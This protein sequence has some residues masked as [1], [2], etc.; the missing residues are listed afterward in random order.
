[1]GYIPELIDHVLKKGM[2]GIS[3]REGG[4]FLVDRDKQELNL[5]LVF[6]KRDEK[7]ARGYRL[8]L[9]EGIAGR[10]VSEDRHIVLHEVQEKSFFNYAAGTGEER[11]ILCVPLKLSAKLVGVGY[12]STERFHNFAEEEITSW[13]SAGEIAAQLLILEDIY[14]GRGDNSDADYINRTRSDL[15]M[16]VTH[17][18]RAPLTV[19][20]EGISLICDGVITD[21]LWEGRKLSFLEAIRHEIDRL[22]RLIQNLAALARMDLGKTDLIIN[23]VS[24]TALLDDVAELMSPLAKKRH[25]LIVKDVPLTLPD[26]PAD[27]DK[28]M[29]VIVNLLNNAIKFTPQDGRI[30]IKAGMEQ[31]SIKICIEDNGMGIQRE[32][33]PRIFNKLYSLNTSTTR[34][35]DGM[36]LGLYIAKAI[37]DSHGGNIWA[38]SEIGKGSKFFFTLPQRVGLLHKIHE[39]ENPCSR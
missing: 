39:E 4:I 15:L 5:R 33:L 9:G 18:I 26:V 14:E 21:K 16:L 25:I 34:S 27:R 29:Q 6:G 8:K 22:S 20:K 17:E 2:E 32:E 31:D 10:A 12:L 28:L 35:S 3:T 7:S 11:S 24:L 1:M 23:P 37:I 36:G 19:I 38:E 30:I 13:T